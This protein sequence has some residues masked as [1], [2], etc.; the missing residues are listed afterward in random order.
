MATKNIRIVGY[1]PPP[2]HEKLREYMDEH[3]LSE[4]AALVKMVKQF[5]DGPVASPHAEELS[6]VQTAIAALQNQVEHLQQRVSLLEAESQP[7]RRQT[8]LVGKS[9]NRSGHSG[10][11]TRQGQADLA[12]RLGVTSKT[13]LEAVEQGEDYFHKWS[14]QRDPAGRAWQKRGSWFYSVGE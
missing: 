2:Y 6:E 1:L 11:L 12:R 10:N 7:S 3:D 13:I 14:Q 5:F 9:P 4:S 8:R